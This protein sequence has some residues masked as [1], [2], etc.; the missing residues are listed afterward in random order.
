MIDGIADV[1]K[2]FPGEVN[3]TQC[4]AHITNL[5]AKSMLKQ[6]DIAKN[7]ATMSKAEKAFQELADDI[8]VK[9]LETYLQ[10]AEDKQGG[11]KDEEDCLVDELAGMSIEEQKAW[12]EQ[13]C[14]AKAILV[15]VSISS[16]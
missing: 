6:F 14:S 11:E 5:I 4:F 8:D 9:E 1:V 16:L 10:E 2:C 3:Y 7:A 12:D 15:K 13:V